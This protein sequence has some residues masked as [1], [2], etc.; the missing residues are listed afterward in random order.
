MEK[1]GASARVVVQQQPV[2]AQSVRVCVCVLL[3]NTD[4]ETFM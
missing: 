2:C 4:V 3:K 1:V